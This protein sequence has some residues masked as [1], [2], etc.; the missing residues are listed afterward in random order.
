M[1]TTNHI[2][3]TA[4][5]WAFRAYDQAWIPAQ[6]GLRHHVK[7]REGF[8][9]RILQEPIRHPVDVWIQAASAGESHLAAMLMERLCGENNLQILAT[10]NTRQGMDILSSAVGRLKSGT[11]GGLQTRYC[12]FDRPTIM[13]RPSRV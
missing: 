12:P 13:Q 3:P 5:R 9:Q 10:T 2:F 6:K 4:I 11:G 7:L 1:H 8:S